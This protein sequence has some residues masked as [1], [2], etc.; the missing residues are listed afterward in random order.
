MNWILH[1]GFTCAWGA[2]ILVWVAGLG[3]FKPT[4]RRASYSS[5]LL[6]FVPL[7][8]GYLLVVFH[9]IPDDWLLRRLWPRTQAI[10]VAGLTMT[11]L[12]CLFA[13]WARVALGTNWSGIPK[14]KEGHALIVKGPYALVRHP[15]YS[16][17]LLALIGTGLAADRGAWLLAWVLVAIAYAVKIRQEERLM[18]ETFPTEY[19]QYRQRVKALIPGIL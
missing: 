6:L 1:A 19:P 14:V 13:I 9:V 7:L 18:H 12:G 8:A 10:Q 16:G 3:F 17:T 15:I 5:R 2:L 4:A 11:V